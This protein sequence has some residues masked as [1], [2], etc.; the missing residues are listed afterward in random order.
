[1]NIRLRMHKYTLPLV[2]PL[3]L[4][5]EVMHERTGWLV[6]CTGADGQTGWGDI[7]PLRGVSAPEELE[8]LASWS[9]ERVEAGMISPAVRCGL[10][11][12]LFNLGDTDLMPRPLR[13][14]QPR[15]GGVPLS[16]LLIGTPE[17]MLRQLQAAIREGY[18]TI[19]IKVGRRAVEEEIQLL[20]AINAHAS[21]T[22]RFRLD[23]NRSW[24]PEDAD[25][26]LSVL[27]EMNVEYV[28]EPFPE[29][30][31]SLAWSRGTGVPVA[32]DESLRRIGVEDLADY[33]GL[34]AVILKPTALG[35]L[36]QAVELAEA[37]AK[38][39]AYPVV[40]AMLES[41]VGTLTLARFAASIGDAD[42]AAGLDTYRWLAADVIEPRPVWQEPVLPASA[43]E[44]SQ[45][46]F[47]EA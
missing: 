47:P 5:G 12:A 17:E 20:H 32:L 7:A 8:L 2:C 42:V 31:A 21:D 23:A 41:G 10:D 46:R 27:T 15:A 28:E 34:R 35:G 16:A 30:R 26:Y 1:M 33:A 6:A 29:P 36:C 22:V 39:E 13:A 44:W 24:S 37:A 43:W 3:N 25:R 14:L 11:M 45:Y 4:A 40:S 18:S 38:I 19:K 9:G